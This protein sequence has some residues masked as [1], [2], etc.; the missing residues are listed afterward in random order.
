MVATGLQVLANLL[1]CM[2]SFLISVL[3]GVVS[4]SFML[5]SVAL[6]DTNNFN[7]LTNQVAQKGGFQTSG[8]ND[9]TLS[10][11]VAKIIK[12]TLGLI[13]TIFLILMVYAGFLWMT[14]GGN[15]DNIGKAKK[16][17]SA[18]VI[19]LA[20]VLA[21]YSITYFVTRVLLKAASSGQVGGS[22]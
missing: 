22:G 4:F 20:I 16:I 11:T 15:E 17:L 3:L 10:Q 2:K 18:S 13:G 6:A 9:T 12:V 7:E 8:V 21:A 5:G 14:G 19:G 1:S